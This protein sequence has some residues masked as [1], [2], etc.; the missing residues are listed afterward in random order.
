MR[1]L[2]LAWRQSLCLHIAICLGGE[3]WSTRELASSLCPLTS[4]LI[5]ALIVSD[6][7]LILMTTLNLNYLLI[8][9]VSKYSHIL[10]YR[11]LEGQHRNWRRH[12][13]Q[14]ITPPSNLKRRLGPL[15]VYTPTTWTT[16]C[17]L[18][19]MP[20]PNLLPLWDPL[21]FLLLFL[22]PISSFNLSLPVCLE[23]L[24]WPATPFPLW[25]S[26]FPLCVLTTLMTCAYIP[27]LSKKAGTVSHSLL[28]L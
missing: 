27:Y 10:S 24:P 25:N 28:D 13:T 6:P 4:L 7:Y 20:V 17:D 16:Y 11:G 5:R 15:A 3:E 2:F 21:I 18:I 1:T 23:S 8:G 14:P 19:S 12:V 9:P 26:G 22:T